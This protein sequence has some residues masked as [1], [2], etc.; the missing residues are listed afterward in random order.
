MQKLTVHWE[1][2]PHPGK[3]DRLHLHNSHHFPAYRF[4]FQIDYLTVYV[5]D[6]KKSPLF[7]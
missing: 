5:P 4:S 3:S 1:N 6:F 7:C 2:T